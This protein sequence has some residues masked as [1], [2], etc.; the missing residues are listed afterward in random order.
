MYTVFRLFRFAFPTAAEHGRP[1]A[2][3]FFGLPVSASRGLSSLSHPPRDTHEDDK[4]RGTRL[5]DI[6]VEHGEECLIAH[7][8]TLHI[9]NTSKTARSRAA[10]CLI[11]L[12]PHYF[13]SRAKLRPIRDKPKNLYYPICTTLSY[14]LPPFL[15]VQEGGFTQKRPIKK[16]GHPG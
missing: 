15:G 8:G 13:S 11:T 9:S 6:S 2:T 7:A 5:C 4:H 1:V 14:E 10:P 12:S 16:M 3:S